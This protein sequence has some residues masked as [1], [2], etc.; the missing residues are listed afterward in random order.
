M[1]VPVHI[2]LECGV[3]IRDSG[4]VSGGGGTY[5]VEVFVKADDR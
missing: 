4:N 3:D 1:G 5:V 2:C